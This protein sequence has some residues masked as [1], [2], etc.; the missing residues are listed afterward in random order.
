M[1]ACESAFLP[2]IAAVQVAAVVGAGRGFSVAT[3]TTT[4]TAARHAMPHE[5]EKAALL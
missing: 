5:K 3:T 4:T 2:S 1:S